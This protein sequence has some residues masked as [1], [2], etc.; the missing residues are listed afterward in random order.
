MTAPHIP[1]APRSIGGR[2]I[3][4]LLLF[5]KVDP[6][7]LTTQIA[8]AMPVGIGPYQPGSDLGAVD[9]STIG[10]KIVVESGNIEPSKMKKFQY[11]SVFDQAPQVRSVILR[12]REMHK[13][14]TP[15]LPESWTT[16]SRSRRVFKPCVSVSIATDHQIPLVRQVAAMQFNHRR[17]S[18]SAR[19]ST[20]YAP[21]EDSGRRLP[22]QV[23]KPARLPIPP[24]GDE[25]ST[26]RLLSTTTPSVWLTLVL[27]SEENKKLRKLPIWHCDATFLGRYR[28][29]LITVRRLRRH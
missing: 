6:Q 23:L 13:W 27:I 1:S 17:Q 10:A 15:S 2:P 5:R 18:R 11:R 22:P 19:S 26:L 28:V 12:C 24:P 14:Q 16:Q 3:R 21:G 29:A 7:K 8:Q 9:R 20:C 25:I 4:R